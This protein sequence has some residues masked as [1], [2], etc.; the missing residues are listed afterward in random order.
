V[1]EDGAI[2]SGVA[3]LPKMT[4]ENV[5]LRMTEK[6]PKRYKENKK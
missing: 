2:D 1:V 6:K 3:L 5:W 4:K